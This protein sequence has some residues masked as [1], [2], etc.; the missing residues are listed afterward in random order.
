MSVDQTAIFGPFL[1]TMLLTVVVWVVLYVRRIR[2]L[3]ESGLTP[4]ELA[5]NPGK[6]AALQPVSV[7]NPSDNFK[8]LFE[9]PVLFYALCLYLFAM[10]QVDAGYVA[11][12][13]VFAG[14]RVLHSAVH[15]TFNRINLRFFFYLVAT[16]AVF[17]MLAR[18]T[19]A[20]FGG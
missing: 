14:F 11:A 4:E 16:L 13:W 1:A 5:L 3:N 18:A 10:Q 6:L 15:C 2:F 7:S 12:G 17:A 20:H 9:V 8:N 19:L